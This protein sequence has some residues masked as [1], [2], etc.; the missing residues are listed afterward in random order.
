LSSLVD[1][2]IPYCTIS[3]HLLNICEVSLNVLGSGNV[4]TN[5]PEPLLFEVYSL[6]GEWCVITIYQILMLEF[7]KVS[8]NKSKNWL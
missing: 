4:K 7:S 1:G 8:R 6:V 5:K 3:K 2:T